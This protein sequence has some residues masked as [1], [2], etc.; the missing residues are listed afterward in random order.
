[1]LIEYT[2]YVQNIRSCINETCYRNSYM[3][4]AYKIQDQTVDIGFDGQVR[5]IKRGGGRGM[6]NKN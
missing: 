3:L 5:G 6:Y 2:L 4:H 1:M